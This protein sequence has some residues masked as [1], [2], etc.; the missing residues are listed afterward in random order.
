MC[1]NKTLKR[2]KSI[3]D[4]LMDLQQ[5]PT[6]KEIKRFLAQ[7]NGD[8]SFFALAIFSIIESYIRHTIPGDE[9]TEDKTKKPVEFWK[10]IYD[11]N[12]KHNPQLRKDIRKAVI[13]KYKKDNNL[14]FEDWLSAE[15]LKSLYPDMNEL[16]NNTFGTHSPFEQLLKEIKDLKR[17]SDRV[18]HDFQEIE[19]DFIDTITEKFIDFA[20]HENFPLIKEI[21]KIPHYANWE[22]C[23]APNDNEQ[24]NKLIAQMDA[25]E[26]AHKQKLT[27][28]ALKLEK[29]ARKN[30]FVEEEKAILQEEKDK[31]NNKYEDLRQKNYELEVELTTVKENHGSSEDITKLENE[32]ES[33]KKQKDEQEAL[34]SRKQKE[35]D[36]LTEHNRSLKDANE[37]YKAEKEKISRTLENTEKERLSIQKEIQELKAQVNQN[38]ETEDKLAKLSD[39]YNKVLAKEKEQENLLIE[40]QKE[41]DV[42]N[43]SYEDLSLMNADLAK[44]KEETEEKLKEAV[45]K[46]NTLLARI[47]DLENNPTPDNKVVEELEQLKNEYAN[48]QAIQESERDNLKQIQEKHLE[49]MELLKKDAELYFEIAN[50]LQSNTSANRNYHSRIL[51][52]STEQNSIINEIYDKI[53]SHKEKNT[54]FLI[55]GGPGTGKT[56]VLIKL[57]EK[58]LTHDPSKKIRLLT[59]TDSLSKYNQYLSEE[60][61]KKSNTTKKT[62]KKKKENVIKLMNNHIETFDSYFKPSISKI[63]GKEIYEINQ[64]ADN[65]KES[66]EYQKLL[67]LFKSVIKEIDY[68]E[69]ALSE[70]LNEIWL[71]C[72]T[73]QS[74]IDNSFQGVNAKLTSK[75]IENRQKIWNYVMKA[76]IELNKQKELPMEFAYYKI[77]TNSDYSILS[78]EYKLDYLLI[79]EIQDLSPSRIKLL[80]KLNKYACVMAG[81]LNQSVFIKRQLSWIE[82]GMKFKDNENDSNIKK[83]VNNYRSTIPVQYLANN[84]RKICKIK[85]DNAISVS[86]IRGQKPDFSISKDLED[87]FK[88]ILTKVQCYIEVMRFNAKDICIV[89]PTDEELIRIKGL[90]SDNHLNALKINDPSF[91]F[92]TS[93]D[94]IRLSTTKMVKGID[95]P[96]IILLL[97]ETFTDLTKNGNTDSMS[98]M[99]S[100]Y[101][102]IT[103]TMDILSIQTTE[104]ALKT[105]LDS[106][107]ENAITK[108]Y[109][110][111]KSSK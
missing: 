54:D 92:R 100:I 74:Y 68:Q 2:N 71:F 42:L 52:L 110:I 62:T 83:L 72:P 66:A 9:Y 46:S 17:L 48:L 19:P 85:D 102:C 67:T 80:S 20:K 41:I 8:P 31:L 111:W 63:L 109:K 12:D 34:L 22:D 11:L 103:R 82:L 45:S 44:Q 53:S 65:Y 73:E 38:S 39:D 88:R 105:N 3:G 77:A 57:L 93:N 43:E 107:E 51:K 91:D 75:Q 10:M 29:E 24:Y 84:Y 40:K 37:T 21:E 33:I 79:D 27:E 5:A 55:K 70:A 99:N 89:V 69:P 49:D 90:L 56:L 1:Y 16:Y 78:D 6:E 7:K 60:Y 14:K 94:V 98:Q 32:L 28:M 36:T 106:N 81:D 18:R 50:I 64:K 58:I 59:Y 108:L 26:E 30:Q 101:S 13:K 96:I 97:S 25:I 47:Q 87:S 95:S 15:D 61:E 86:F 35:I 104:K 76:T 23:K 4:L